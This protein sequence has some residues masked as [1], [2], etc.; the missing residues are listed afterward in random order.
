VALGR[1]AN[2]DQINGALVADAG[3]L[4]A[5]GWRPDVDTGDALAAMTAFMKFEQ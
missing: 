1:G 3:K 5:V 2:W 4:R